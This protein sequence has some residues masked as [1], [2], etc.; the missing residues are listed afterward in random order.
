MPVTDTL[1]PTAQR[2]AARGRDELIARL[3]PAFEEAARAHADVLEL[4]DA[5]LEKMIQRAADRADGLQWRRALA[6]VA[7]HELGISL[8]EALSHPA[9]AR[10]QSIVG[11][12]SYEEGLAALGHVRTES[13]NGNG[14]SESQATA[15]S[16]DWEE[17][18]FEETEDDDDD[19]GLDDDDAELE[20]AVDL[21]DSELEASEVDDE[22]DH[23]DYD[24][25]YDEDELDDEEPETGSADRPLRIAAVHLGGIANLGP[26]ESGLEL[27][28]SRYGLDIARGQ[29]EVLGRLPWAQIK[30]LE[31]PDPR[32]FRRRRRTETSLVVRTAHGDAS[33]QIPSLTPE[34]LRDHLEPLS[35][36]HAQ[37]P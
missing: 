19:D 4:D 20:D 15:V 30:A 18:E 24:D 37:V 33:F 1:E 32:G 28:F 6:A 12:P 31:V 11:A 35:E 8:G 5:Q 23:E 27:R 25:D 7:S 36:R 21:E 16:E 9:V 14:S 29:T 26:G 13:S 22:Y 3:R 17:S 10:A 2:I 34:E